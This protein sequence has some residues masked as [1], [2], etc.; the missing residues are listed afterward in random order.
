RFSRDWSSDVCSSDL[1]NT[2]LHA[3]I[4]QRGADRVF[5]R[6]VGHVER[7]AHAVEITLATLLILA[8]AEIGQHLVPAPAAR[9]GLRP[10]VIIRALPANIEQAVDG[11]GAAQH[12]ALGPFV[13]AAA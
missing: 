8:L 5:L 6:E 12:L 10:A 11:G 9:A 4:H 1:G 7:P 3:G 2:R 13:L